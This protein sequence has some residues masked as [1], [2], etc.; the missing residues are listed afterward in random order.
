MSLA[1]GRAVLALDASGLSG[2][3]VKRTFRGAEVKAA[4]RVSLEPGVLV[5]S[6]LLANLVRPAAV[7]TALAELLDRLGRPARATLVLP[8]G[9]ARISLLRPPEGTEAREYARFRLAPGL[10]FPLAEA[11]VDV[12]PAGG[13]RFLAAAVRREVVAG[14]E[15]LL[16]GGGVEVERVDLMPLPAV[17]ARRREHLPS[18]L[19]LFLGDVAFAVAFHEGGELRA[20]STRFRDRGGDELTRIGRSLAG[21]ERAH[22]AAVRPRVLVFGAGCHEVAAGLAREGFPASPGPAEALLGAAA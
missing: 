2:A 3:T 7:K 6:P 18:V 19:D 12:V 1:S 14:Y 11:I 9:L 17:A 22:P 20:F 15:E 16:A 13:A 5:P 10:P 4:E 21:A 8:L